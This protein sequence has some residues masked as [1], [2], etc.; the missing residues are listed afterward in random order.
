MQKYNKEFYVGRHANTE[1]AAKHI[2]S[3]VLKLCPPIHS[4]IDIGCGVGTWLKALKD[5][6]IEKV[7][8]IDG[9]WVDSEELVIPRDCF[10]SHDFNKDSNLDIKE[11]YD[12]VICLEVAEHIDVGKAQEFIRLLCDLSDIILFSAAIPGQGGIG[13]V[14]EQW[15]S[16]WSRIFQEHGYLGKD[17]LRPKFWNDSRIPWWYRQNLLLFTSDDRVPC[18]HDS[19][20][21][22]ATMSLVHPELLGN[23]TTAPEKQ[24]Y[25]SEAFRSLISSLGDWV[26]RRFWK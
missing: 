20:V 3:F 5:L 22:F 21:D 16:Y 15:P 10:L 8:G 2:L 11:R 17:V 19:C 9:P 13:H 12:I 14:N 4:G 7:L 25:V 1:Y 6:G 26:T 24:M 18:C 23:K